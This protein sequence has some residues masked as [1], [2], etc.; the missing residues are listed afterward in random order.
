[1]HVGQIIKTIRKEKGMT[2]KQLG[3]KCGMFDS[4]IRKYESGRQNPK[5]ETLVKIANALEV[6][7]KDLLFLNEISNM[8]SEELSGIIEDENFISNLI[9]DN[10]SEEVK[11]QH[12]RIKETA[13]IRFQEIGKDKEKLLIYYDKLN[14]L[15]KSKALERTEE[16]TH[17]E[18]YTASDN[19][20]E[21]KK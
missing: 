3:E 7:I 17:I 2:Q 4:A 1:M 21:K 16:L 6:N 19:S 20:T 15:G 18:K 9:G 14:E 13:N 10:I 11:E 5:Y 8:D 12:K